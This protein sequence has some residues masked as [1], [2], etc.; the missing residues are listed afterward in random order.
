MSGLRLITDLPDDVTY[1]M[2]RYIEAPNNI[3][4]ILCHSITPL[5]KAAKTYVESN[6]NLWEAILSGYYVDNDNDKMVKQSNSKK[7]KSDSAFRARTQRRSS[8]RLRR[9]T[10]R[11]DVIHAHFVL[12]DQVRFIWM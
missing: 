12:R 3:A 10:A 1:K 8:K 6:D 7:G 9:T 5:C 4:F 11:E 2:L